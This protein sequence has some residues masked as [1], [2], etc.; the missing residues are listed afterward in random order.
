MIEQNRH[1]LSI[2]SRSI[3][4]QRQITDLADTDKFLYFVK[5]KLNNCFINSFNQQSC[6]HNHFLNGK[7]QEK[8]T[9]PF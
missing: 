8:Y 9:L 7:K 4:W 2:A 6:F 1:D 3:I 5:T